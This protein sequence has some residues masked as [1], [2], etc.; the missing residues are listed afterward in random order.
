MR[1][2]VYTDKTLARDAGRFV[3]LSIDIE[4][5][6]N[7][8]FQQKF[9]LQDLP[10]VYIIDSVDETL[11]GRWSGAKTVPQLEKMFSEGERLVKALRTEAQKKK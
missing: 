7:E 3:W 10:A 4:K 2:S 9:P 1:A 11:A 6:Q 8:V 5:A